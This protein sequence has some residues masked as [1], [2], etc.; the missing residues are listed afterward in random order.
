MR[1]LCLFLLLANALFFGWAELI[2]V[3]PTD[4]QRRTASVNPPARIMLAREASANG[5]AESLASAAASS[6]EAA[7]GSAPVPTPAAPAPTTHA[8]SGGTPGACT[9]VGPFAE[10][11]EAATAE[12]AL[13][14]AGFKPRQR[15]VQGE[16]FV[17]YWV[18]IPGLASRE[19]A[20]QALKQ[21]ADKGMN[22]V[23][24]L[25]GTESP[26]VLSLG[27]FSDRQRAQRRA[28]DARSVGLTARIDER[29]RTGAVYWVDV[30]QPEPIQ[31]VDTS[32]FQTEPGKINRLEL[33]ACPAG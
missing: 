27:V 6:S 2:D 3:R 29:K 31:P 8:E 18:S 16:M 9:S 5:S 11:S 21:L 33:K 1:T 24:V 22:D 10:S 32:I 19:A 28:D 13:R 7:S 4:L 15:M 26:N 20:N 30:D 23:Y 25:P 14:Q 12:T 17:G